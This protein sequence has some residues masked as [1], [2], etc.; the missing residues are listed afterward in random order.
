MNGD[1]IQLSDYV[2]IAKSASKRFRWAIVILV[3]ASV[4]AAIATFNTRSND[5]TTL[6]I[7]SIKEK[8]IDLYSL[9]QL[10]P[11]QQ[12]NQLYY[13]NLS[14]LFQSR[15]VESC[16]IRVPFFGVA[17]DV[18]DLGV[19]SGFSFVIILIM[20]RF[21]RRTELNAFRLI[22]TRAKNL[23]QLREYYNL[24]SMTRI[25]TIPPSKLNPQIK[26]WRLLPSLLYVL[27]VFVQ[28]YVFYN[29]CLTI[30]EPYM[31][32]PTSVTIIMGG[33]LISLL[34]IIALSVNSLIYEN[35]FNK[36]WTKTYA[37][38]KKNNKV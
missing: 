19:V 9:K 6:R 15:W 23:G 12:S 25:L 10:T 8:L 37:E 17:I 13:E 33:S 38:L 22:F 32:S 24:L 36:L 14:H 30:Y 29:D 31:A 16:Y 34:L 20:L 28:F 5:W 4:L 11:K 21:S 27:P 3:L 1:N 2:K 18:N 35:K 26:L 7:K